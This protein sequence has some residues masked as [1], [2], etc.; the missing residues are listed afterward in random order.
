MYYKKTNHSI[1]LF[2]ILLLITSCANVKDIA[3][4]QNLGSNNANALNNQKNASGLSN[5]TIKPKDLL[6][7]T[8]VS[9]EPEASRMYN[10]VVPQI[11]ET[12]KSSALFSQ[13]VLQ[14]YLV[15]NEGTI[16]FPALGKIKVAGFTRKEIE[17]ALHQKLASSFTKETPIITIRIVNF[18]VNILGE[19]F[20][21]GKYET[22]NDRMTIFDGLALAGD[23][24]VYA[25]RDNVKILRENAIGTKEFITLNLNDRNIIYSPAYFLEQNDVIYVEPNKSKS[26]SS[27]FGS[28]ETFWISSVS[29]ML[30]LTSLILTVVRK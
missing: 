20:K 28:A 7:I 2:L 19:V 24:T 21:P 27:N 8:V 23:M 10:L 12:F 30:T 25:R 3:Y 29:I 16:E 5:A 6:S 9:S 11:S 4:F 26:R 13:P 14:T 17:T 15:D 1:F 18:T 22:I